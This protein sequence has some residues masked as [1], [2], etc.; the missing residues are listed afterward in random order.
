MKVIGSLRTSL[1]QSVLRGRR[2][3]TSSKSLETPS[4]AC[5]HKIN[6]VFYQY[7]YPVTV[8]VYGLHPLRNPDPAILAPMH[9]GNLNCVLQ[10]GLGHFIG[11]SRGQ[12]LTP[13]RCQE[14]QEWEERV[15]ITGTM[16]DDVTEVEN[17]LKSFGLLCCGTV[18]VSTC[19]IA[20]NSRTRIYK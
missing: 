19:L 10:R 4:Q 3:R 11:A 20:A 15:H 2:G 18:L 16:V 9:D 1:T 6:L 7:A 5:R 13:T 14:I 12:R 8:V 17:I